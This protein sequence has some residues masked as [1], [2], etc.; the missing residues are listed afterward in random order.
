MVE[1]SNHPKVQQWYL[2]M[3][4]TMSFENDKYSVEKNQYEWCFSKSRRAQAIDPQMNMQMRNN[5]L[6]TQMPGELEHAVNCR[7]NHNCTLE[8]ISNTLRDVRKRTNLGKDTPYKRNDFKEKQP[9]CM[10]FKT[11]PEK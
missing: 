9:C 10:E 3:R 2:D 8:D 6:L 11:N 1:E 5:T 7:C 4:K